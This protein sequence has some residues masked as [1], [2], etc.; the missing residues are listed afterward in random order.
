VTVTKQLEEIIVGSMNGQEDHSD[1][2]PI[3]AYG[4][5]RVLEPRGALP[6]AA[7]RI[8]AVTPMQPHEIE[9]AVDTLCLD[10]TSFRQLVES[11]DRDEDR[12][13]RAIEKIV[14]ERGK[15]DNPVTGSGG[16]LTGIVR[17]VGTTFRNPPE[18][19]E[20]IVPLSSLTLT[21]LNLEAVLG[22]D[23]RSAHVPVRGTAFVPWTVPWTPC[24][25]DLPFDATLA[26]L[27]VGNAPAQ[28]RSLIGPDTRTVL[29]LGGGHA[30]LLALAAARETLGS[31]GRAILIDNSTSVCERAKELGL[32]D[33]ALSVDLRDAIGALTAVTALGIPRA[34]LTIV[35]VNATDCEGAA[36]LL[37]ADHGTIL[38]FS[39]ATSFAKAALG[40]E[41]AASG[42]RMIVGSGYAQDRGVY[43]LDLIRH[44][45]NLRSVF[46]AGG[47]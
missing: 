14:A 5:G 2:I 28:T 42:A 37:T 40:S 38:F 29:V 30:G 16:V 22:V 3:E 25:D 43:A 6:Q 39:M 24:P 21:P 44:N 23:L 9:I 10:S 31:E 8:D 41:G 17:A 1:A 7:L 47:H 4:A 34:D 11:N 45:E 20:R 13:A 18:V 12:V 33:V 19:G 36:L 35:V 46:T 15:M 27:D 32:C 26:A